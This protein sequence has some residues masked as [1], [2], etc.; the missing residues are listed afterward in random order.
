MLEQPD[1]RPGSGQLAA[2]R[3]REVV[4]AR[5]LELGEPVAAWRELGRAYLAADQERPA[6]R[7]ALA[8][9]F[10]VAV[11]GRAAQ[12][13]VA[14]RVRHALVLGRLAGEGRE[15]AAR[16][17]DVGRAQQAVAVGVG[18]AVGRNAAAHWVATLA[19]GAFGAVVVADA[20]VE[21]VVARD[22]AALG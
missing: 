5:R 14:V 6:D 21:T 7:A 4:E 17:V 20:T 12:P 18:G 13:C 3:L 15:V 16:I 22:L 8:H 9:A 10:A 2:R 11:A 1:L 19:D